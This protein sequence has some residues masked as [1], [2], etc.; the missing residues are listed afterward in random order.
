MVGVPY[1]GKYKEIFNSDA[2]EFGGGGVINPRVK[3]SRAVEQDERKDSIKIKVP[4][5]GVSVFRFTEAFERTAPDR[6]EKKPD[7]TSVK[8]AKAMKKGETEKT[9]ET[10]KKAAV[11]KTEKTVKKV[12]AAASRKMVN[13]RR[14]KASCIQHGLIEKRNVYSRGLHLRGFR[15][16]LVTL[17]VD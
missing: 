5:L 14:G 4:P 6:E 17:I 12:A 13:R 11:T 2:A 15:G 8:S 9:G 3:L 1:A 10:L 16:I 7:R